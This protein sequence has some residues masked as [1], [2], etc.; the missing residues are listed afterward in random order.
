MI[1]FSVVVFPAPLRPSSVTT[2]PA[3]TSKFAPWRM[4]DSPYQACRPST[5]SKAAP[6]GLSMAHPKIG[7][8][9]ARI[10]RNGLIVSLSE[11]A[12]SRK[13]GDV[14]S[15]VGD[16]AQIV[17]DHQHCAGCADGFDQRTDTINVL[18]SH[19]GG[20]LVQ[21]KHFRLECKRRGDLQR[22]FAAIRQFPRRYTF[23]GRQA[24]CGEE[25]HCSVV[26]RVENTFRPPE[27]E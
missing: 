5:A 14:V 26:E 17:L 25:H 3:N 2:S 27:I 1:A 15:K 20:R 23:K 21:Q 7:F 16:D 19:P 18:L 12:A 9:H 11:H 10:V 13:H 4:C 24:H 8:A 6:V 22:A